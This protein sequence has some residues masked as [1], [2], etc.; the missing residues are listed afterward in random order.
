MIK[1]SIKFIT[2]ISM[3][4][5]TLACQQKNQS[6]ELESPDQSIRVEIQLS[7]QDEANGIQ[8]SVSRLMEGSYVDIM[9]PS[10]L[11]IERED[12]DFL[13]GLEPESV[14]IR[15]GIEDHYTL[16]SGK[17]LEYSN[18]YNDIRISLKNQ[19]KKIMVLNFR[20]YDYGLA[21]NYHFP[22]ESEN[23]VRVIQEFSGFNFKDGNF[24]A[25]AYDTLTKWNPA[26]ET[27]YEGPVPVGTQAP[28]NK[29]GWAFP[30]LIESEDTWMLVSEAGFDGSYGA[31]HLQSECEN[32]EYLIRFA[33][34]GEAEGYYENT[35]QSTLP[36]TTAWRFIA[37]GDSPA[38]LVETSLPTDLSDPVAIKDVSWIKPG[39]ASWS[40]WSES[41]SPQDYE[42]LVP[43]IDL[44][45]DM[46]WEYSLVDANWNRMT[47]G[48]IE[49]LVKYAE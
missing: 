22:G 27:Y 26:Y 15:K 40:W 35:S 7:N 18:I 8:Y 25:H 23:S 45:A 9:D 34:Q 2:V 14:E 19:D 21:F 31:S 11:G 42:R 48:N 39:R 12:T 29:N 24:W 37:I 16:L 5:L 28:W 43:F 20:V 38:E 30:I 13:S 44:A 49:K 4:I 41:D 17:K 33:E 6:W 10:P 1:K 46:G 36:W 32:G 47:N 3:L